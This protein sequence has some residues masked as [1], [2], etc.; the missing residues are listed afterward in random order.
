MVWA[1]R[2]PT[3]SPAAI[4]LLTKLLSFNPKKR[5]SV[6]EAIQHEYF[7]AIT[8]LETPPT[9]QVKFNWEWEYLHTKL[10]NS[11][12]FVKKLIFM[13]SLRFHP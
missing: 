3:A 1:K 12:P 5:I 8:K 4:D 6:Y 11:I 9:S 13:E 10:L 2:F 7:A